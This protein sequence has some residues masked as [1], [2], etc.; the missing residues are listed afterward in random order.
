MWTTTAEVN[1]LGMLSTGAAPTGSDSEQLYRLKAEVRPPA[2][3]PGS[4]R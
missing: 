4:T 1:F 3:P 2:P